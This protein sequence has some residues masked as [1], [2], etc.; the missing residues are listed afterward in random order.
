MVVDVL[1]KKC[2]LITFFR[3]LYTRGQ[4]MGASSIDVQPGW[5]NSPL[6]LMMADPSTCR[7]TV[8]G[9][10]EISQDFA[11]HSATSRFYYVY[12]KL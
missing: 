5:L 3:F 4:M 12:R 10:G 1:N 6:G 2:L 8:W 7:L 9:G 11:H